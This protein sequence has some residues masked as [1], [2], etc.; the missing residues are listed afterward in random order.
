MSL[1]REFDSVFNELLT[2]S[3]Q[4]FRE[5]MKYH[6][7]KN[8]EDF[9]LEVSLPGTTKNDVDVSVEKDSLS[10]K[11]KKNDSRFSKAYNHMWLLTK[12]HDVDNVRAVMENGVLTVKIG[13]VKPEKKVVN[14]TVN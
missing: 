14:V 11:V 6:T 3:Q 9:I 4:D 12:E 5:R 13:R 8:D 10:V 7:S 1:A 2:A